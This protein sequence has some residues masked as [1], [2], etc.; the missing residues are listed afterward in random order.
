VCVCVCV[1]FVDFFQ[2]DLRC[3]FSP[4]Q[5]NHGGVQ[6]P[7]PPVSLYKSHT[8]CPEHFPSAR[9][10]MVRSSFLGL[11]E[12]FKK[13]KSSQIFIVTHRDRGGIGTHIIRESGLSVCV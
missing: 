1:L 11:Q 8:T 4:H 10:P 9:L 7:P 5:V 12:K 6:N 3:L 2:D 13:D